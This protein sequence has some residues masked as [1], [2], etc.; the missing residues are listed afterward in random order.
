MRAMRPALKHSKYYVTRAASAL[1][2]VTFGAAS[3]FLFS[4]CE[5]EE[6]AAA[7]AAPKYLY[8]ASGACY[9][10][11]GITSFTNATSSNLVYRLNLTTGTKE[12]TIADLSLIHI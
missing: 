5:E 4:G 1:V 12:R 6:E 3:I 11:N 10:G 2:T 7:G 9:S 8:V